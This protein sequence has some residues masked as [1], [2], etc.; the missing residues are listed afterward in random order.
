MPTYKTRSGSIDTDFFHRW[1]DRG[2]NMAGGN[3][4]ILTHS[5]NIITI[6]SC[7]AVE[8]ANAMRRLDI[9]GH[10]H[11]AGTFY[12]TKT[13]SQEFNRSYHKWP[14]YKT[15]PMWKVK[16]GY[17][18]PF[19]DP[20]STFTSLKELEAWS[21]EIDR[22][23]DEQ[24]RSADIIVVTI[25]LIEAWYRRC[26]G[27]FFRQFPCD[28][29]RSQD[30]AFKRLTVQEMLDDL[31]N[32]YR[33]ISNNTKASLILTV[34][35]IPLGATFINE[36]VRIANVESKSRIRAAVSEF[37]ERHEKVH[38]FHSFELVST[39]ECLSDFMMQDGRHVHRH[40]ADYIVQQ[41]L[42][43]FADHSIS[44]T[45]IDTSWI[46]TP[47]KCERSDVMLNKMQS[48]TRRRD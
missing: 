11:P 40:A 13:I 21:D 4:P 10:L 8:L 6:G 22:I 30:L 2:D 16:N 36:H 20:K 35:P 42:S 23:A 3:I 25:G 44:V 9:K 14:N 46:T 43:K 37:V 32:I 15:E 5:S 24:F 33:I 7:F 18:H 28:Q 19:K 17:A 39:A 41:F 48:S 1:H 31:E 45:P 26:T 12:N 29:E 27:H 38:Y 47:T 34:S